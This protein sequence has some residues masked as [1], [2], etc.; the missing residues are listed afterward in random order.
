MTFIP[1]LAQRSK[2]EG[3]LERVLGMDGL[4]KN[5]KEK[6]D[7]EKKQVITQTVTHITLL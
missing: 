3:L 1:V 7:K 6:G 4:N 2:R 5:E